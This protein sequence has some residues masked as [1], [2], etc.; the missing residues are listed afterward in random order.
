MPDK[1]PNI[2]LIVSDDTGYGESAL[3]AE[4]T[5]AACRPRTSTVS[6][7]KV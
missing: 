1:K 3:T 4:A 2:I 6:Q 5:D 7:T